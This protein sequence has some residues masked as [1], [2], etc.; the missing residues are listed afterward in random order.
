[1][2]CFHSSLVGSGAGFGGGFGGQQEEEQTPKG[3]TI[4]IDLDLTLKD[5]YL[6]RT[7]KVNRDKAV[8][9][10]GKGTRQCNCKTRM[11]TRQIA[12]GMYQQY[13]EQKCEQCQALK[14]VRERETLSVEVERGMK[15]GQEIVFFEQGEPLMDGEPGDLKFRVVT[16]PHPNVPF[17]RVGDDLHVQMPITLTEA[18]VGFRKEFPHLDGHAVVLESSGISRPGD[19]MRLSREG[20]PVGAFGDKFGDLFVKIHVEFPERLSGEQKDEVKALFQGT[21][22]R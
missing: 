17:E 21:K 5:L 7:F 18:L 13:P 4:L 12:P 16:R 10:P 1:M 6:G 19:V 9:K 3:K 22:F 8:Y 14:L 2:T 11:L 20:M 15:D